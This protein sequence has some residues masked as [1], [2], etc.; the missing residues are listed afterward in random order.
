MVMSSVLGLQPAGVTVQRNVADPPMVR[1]VTFEVAEEGDTTFADP[2]ITDQLPEPMIGGVATSV[3]ES[4]LQRVW[5]A[6]ALATEPRS[7]LVMIT[8]SVDVPHTPFDIVHLSVTE[9]PTTSPVT[10]E[11]GDEGVVTVA[12]PDT[13]DHSPVPTVGLFPASVAMVTLHRF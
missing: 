1:P 12:V 2:E 8:S 13:T 7:K 4:W 9:E 6:P 5:S 3:V 10:P 11:E